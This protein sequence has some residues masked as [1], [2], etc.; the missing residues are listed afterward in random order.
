R[1]AALSLVPTTTGAARACGL[2]LP[3]LAGRLDGLAVRSPNP[4][5]SI[6]DLTCV[7]SK[8]VRVEAVND[9]LREAAGKAPLAGI[10]GV[11]DEELVSADVVGDPRSAI[12]DAA[13]TM[14][15]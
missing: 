2:V 14:A 13:S 8:E 15:V 5:G 1:A 10:L 4:D 12:V 3:S 6:V 11:T 9:A 7:L